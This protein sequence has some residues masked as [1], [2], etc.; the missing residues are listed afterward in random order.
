QLNEGLKN[1]EKGEFERSLGNLKQ[2]EAGVGEAKIIYE[3]FEPIRKTEFLKGQFELGDNL[4]DLSFLSVSAAKNTALGVQ[5]L[6]QSI[7]TVTGEQ[8]ESPQKYFDNAQMELGSAGENLSKAETILT[9]KSFKDGIP[10]PF[11]ARISELSDKLLS[12]RKLAAKAEAISI[13]LPKLVGMNGARNYLVLLQNNMELRP[14]GGFIGSFAE[15]SFEAGKLKKIEVNDI[16]AI[17]GQLS[18]HIEPPVEI[19]ED[20]GQKNFYLRDSN[21]E[22][23]FPT[24]ARQA[25]WFYAKE[26][27]KSV[28]GVVALDVS[29]MEELLAVI[30]PLDLPDYKERITS[31][32]LFERAV[33]HAETSF[34]PGTQAKKSFLTALSNGVFEKIFFLPQNNWPGIISALGKSLEE[35]HISFYLNDPKQFQFLHSQNWAHVLPRQSKENESKD[36]LS[37]VEA[38]LGANKVNYYLDRSYNLHTIIGKEG[39][40]S[41]RLR[42]NYINRSPS[43]AFPGGKYKN[44]MRIYLPFGAKL[45]RAIW[46]EAEITGSVN[47]F[48]DYG[49]SGYSFLL[50][51]SPK[52]QKMLVID[53]AV[54]IMLDFQDG[55]AAYRLDIIKQAGLGKDPLQWTVTY[56][57]SYR[58]ASNQTKAT[59]PQEQ[60]IST[61]LS[62]DRSFEIEFRK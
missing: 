36:F 47:G 46:G 9:G 2:A 39:E 51:L 44:R 14:A 20:L 4:L 3:S 55:K 40:V 17:D 32:N 35:K 18:V 33:T 62:R 42:I 24:S 45:T 41:Q 8:S 53:Y 16:Y 12:Y 13:L 57:I 31:E 58:I 28:E 15:V 21:W 61:D 10:G 49:R 59:S 34:F 23:D 37:I 48:V 11:K 6:L 56:P 30:G 54:P 43:E 7:K 22:P 50:E 52:E 1:L 5:A 19:K 38:N 26:T 60:T 25:E 27:G 29:A